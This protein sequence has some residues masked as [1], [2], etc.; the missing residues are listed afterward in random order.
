[1]NDT[2]K[3]VVVSHLLPLTNKFVK[4]AAIFENKIFQCPRC[5]TGSLHTSSSKIH[6]KIDPK[7]K[8]WVVK[9]VYDWGII[10]C[11][12]C[13]Y[14]SDGINEFIRS[15]KIR[16]KNT[17]SK[18]IRNPLII[19]RESDAK[20]FSDFGKNKTIKITNRKVFES[21][22]GDLPQE[23]VND[24]IEDTDKKTKWKIEEIINEK[25]NREYI[26]KKISSTDVIGFKCNNCGSEYIEAKNVKANLKTDILSEKFEVGKVID[27]G[28]LE[29][30]MCGNKGK[31]NQNKF[32][33]V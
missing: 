2:E 23:M 28:E 13:G 24:I 27:F 14:R 12:G 9:K 29:C 20:Y 4:K 33:M 32:T 10:V 31:V 30:I 25:Q 7:L 19:D 21:I 26:L 3:I 16:L 8:D 22:F 5:N 1:M 15:K 17:P 6:I 11:D 18:K